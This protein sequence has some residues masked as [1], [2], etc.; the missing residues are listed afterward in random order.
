MQ[1][2]ALS[3]QIADSIDLKAFKTLSL[4]KYMHLTVMNSS[5]V[6]MNINAFMFLN[7]GLFVSSIMMKLK[8]PNSFSSSLLFAKIFS[9]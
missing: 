9:Q 3:Y 7:M 6:L 5:T 1:L 2:K 8:L 4:L